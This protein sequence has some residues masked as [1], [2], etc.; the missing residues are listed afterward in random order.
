MSNSNSC[1]IMP[2]GQRRKE[3]TSDERQKTQSIG[4]E[5]KKSDL[6]VLIQ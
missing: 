3:R 1:L 4:V 2:T 6:I 5:G